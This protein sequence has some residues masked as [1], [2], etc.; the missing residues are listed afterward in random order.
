MEPTPATP[1]PYA[2]AD[3]D[4][5][6]R[7]RPGYPEAALEALLTRV[8]PVRSVADIGAGT[9][10]FA[11]QLLDLEPQVRVE[12]VEPA[13]EMPRG[14]PTQPRLTWHRGTSE[15]TGLAPASV[16]LVVWAQ[17]FHWVDRERTGLEASRILAPG[18][19][20]AIIQNQMEVG[21]PWVHR[22]S[23]IMR[24]GDVIRAD[25]NP[26]LPGFETRPVQVFPWV[27]T[28]TVDEVMALA[29]T[30]SSYLGSGP[31]RQRRMQANLNWYLRDHL[32][33]PKE[34]QV[35]IPHLT[36]LWILDPA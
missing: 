22:L 6:H 17:S 29:R 35:R 24:S 21:E 23:R 15:A 27:Q 36:F 20:G 11:R 12:A 26:R 5:Y 18:G 25:W 31:A 9:G 10:I 14:A 28:L 13:P 3:P 8:G 16:D 2:Q 30:R 7:V 19:H 33:Y 1:N 4:L 34:G 32:A